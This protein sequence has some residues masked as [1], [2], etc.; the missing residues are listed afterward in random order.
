MSLLQET[1]F[2]RLLPRYE[3]AFGAPPPFRS[4][5]LD[6]VIAHMRDRLA[7]VEQAPAQ[8]TAPN[9]ERNRPVVAPP[10]NRTVRPI[11]PIHAVH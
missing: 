5:S 11:D 2:E 9:S 6:E 3:R 7:T 8:N 1:V 4:A 10:R